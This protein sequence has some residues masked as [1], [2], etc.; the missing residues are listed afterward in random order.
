MTFLSE[1]SAGRIKKKKKKKNQKKQK[2]KKR[3]KKNFGLRFRGGDGFTLQTITPHAFFRTRIRGAI[4]GGSNPNRE[5]PSQQELFLDTLSSF[6]P[7]RLH[8]GHFREGEGPER[9]PLVPKTSGG[10]RAG[11][12]EKTNLLGLDRVLLEQGAEK[13]K[14]KV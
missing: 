4:S 6:C 12:G 9:V 5:K 2:E 3:K 10:I 1:K 13:K 14:E 8:F 7:S 11:P